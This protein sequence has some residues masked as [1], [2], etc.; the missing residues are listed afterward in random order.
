MLITTGCECSFSLYLPIAW[1]TTTARHEVSTIP[2]V[3]IHELEHNFKWVRR[4]LNGPAET[5]ATLIV[6][7]DFDVSYHREFH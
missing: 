1:T 6:Y 4:R 3:M 7:S 5:F 2:A